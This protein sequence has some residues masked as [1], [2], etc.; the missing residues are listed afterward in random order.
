MKPL[1]ISGTMKEGEQQP[2]SAGIFSDFYRIDTPIKKEMDN[3][4]PGF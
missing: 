2:E 3:L 4:L 1:R